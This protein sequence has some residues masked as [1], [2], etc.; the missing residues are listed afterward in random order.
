ML[1]VIR[2]CLGWVLY[3][4]GALTEDTRAVALGPEHEISVC[5][6]A[7]PLDRLGGHMSASFAG[8][9]CR[10][11]RDTCV[12]GV[13]FLCARCGPDSAAESREKYPVVE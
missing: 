8:G 6:T 9:F 1:L 12:Q 7:R 5:K 4:G 10:E 2:R 3:H 11:S 13:D